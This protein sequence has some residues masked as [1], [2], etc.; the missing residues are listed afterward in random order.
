[1]PGFKVLR[2]KSESVPRNRQRLRK[3]NAN[4][5]STGDFRAMHVSTSSHPSK[6]ALAIMRELRI[7]SFDEISAA[8]HR[9]RSIF[10]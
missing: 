6:R 8:R 9:L 4:Y 2:G 1:M 7:D 5:G 10:P 3:V